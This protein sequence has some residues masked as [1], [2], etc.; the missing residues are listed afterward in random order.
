[1]PGP[2]LLEGGTARRRVS[3]QMVVGIAEE[4]DRQPILAGTES[5]CVQSVFW[6]EQVHV[7][8]ALLPSAL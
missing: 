7:T 2:R 5:S 6:E 1:M 3:E 4:K 8:R